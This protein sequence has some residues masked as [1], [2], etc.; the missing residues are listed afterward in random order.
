M[1]DTSLGPW[2]YPDI[3]RLDGRFVTVERLDPRRDAADL[4]R[5]SHNPPEYQG[6]F[7]FLPYGPFP[8]SDAMLDWLSQIVEEQDFVLFLG[9]G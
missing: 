1:E 6:L 5:V 9:I 3:S 2:Q 4:Y 8:S 7:T